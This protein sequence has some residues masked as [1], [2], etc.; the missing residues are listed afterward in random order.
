MIVK[1]ID[2][3]FVHFGEKL[4]YLDIGSHSVEEVQNAIYRAIREW[5]A[6]HGIYSDYCIDEIFNLLPKE[7]KDIRLTEIEKRIYI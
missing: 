6:I 4:G 2:D 3:S 5:N 1:L 7:F